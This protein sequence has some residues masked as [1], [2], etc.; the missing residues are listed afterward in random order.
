ME[1]HRI[2]A[3]DDARNVYC[4]AWALLTGTE[5][6]LVSATP[7][8]GLSR[9]RAAA[10]ARSL[11]RRLR[12]MAKPLRIGA[13]IDATGS[14]WLRFSGLAGPTRLLGHRRS[15]LTAGQRLVRRPRRLTRGGCEGAWQPS[16][17]WRG[18][19]RLVPKQFPTLQ[20]TAG[21]RLRWNL[22]RAPASN[23]TYPYCQPVR[24][25]RPAPPSRVELS[26]LAW[27]CLIGR[28]EVSQCA[29]RPA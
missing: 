11:D 14:V 1:H 10:L 2:I 25:R 5:F 12:R 15:P 9:L 22:G 17:R 6:A 4:V 28:T 16:S 27:V 29:A 21:A 24:R 7:A 3:C 18:F 8:S 19:N 26:S 20:G 13:E 23:G